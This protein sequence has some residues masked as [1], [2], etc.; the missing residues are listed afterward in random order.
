[1]N[2]IENEVTAEQFAL[3]KWI[4]TRLNAAELKVAQQQQQQQQ[5]KGGASSPATTTKQPQHRPSIAPNTV[6]AT[7][8]DAQLKEFFDV[9]AKHEGGWCI[10]L[11]DDAGQLAT[12]AS[13]TG[14]ASF[15]N[16]FS[17]SKVMFGVLKV[18]GVDVKS[19]VESRRLKLVQV[20]WVGQQMQGSKRMQ[21]TAM[22]AKA[23][24]IITGAAV[25][26]ELSDKD[27][28]SKQAIGKKLLASG[29]AHKPMFY[30]FGGDKNDILKIE[31]IVGAS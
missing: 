27:D 18:V 31:D 1:M 19:T 13:G 17:D 28:L 16:S 8:Q 12:G 22:K 30:E 25:S 14:F 2:S 26:F 15:L 3:L 6:V 11:V 4:E 10:F 20:N 29:G 7:P 23:N 5:T 24:S 9:V 21:G